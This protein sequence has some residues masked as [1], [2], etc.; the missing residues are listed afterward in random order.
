M[1]WLYV[2]CKLLILGDDVFEC[3]ARMGLMHSDTLQLS[4]V[5]LL[6]LLIRPGETIIFYGPRGDKLRNRI[7]E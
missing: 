3:A 7:N 4:V 6:L 2:K 5:L 1:A